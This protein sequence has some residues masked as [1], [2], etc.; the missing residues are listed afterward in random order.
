MRERRRDF[1]GL[2]DGVNIAFFPIVV[3]PGKYRRIAM[4]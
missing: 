2:G 4:A 3:V 1:L